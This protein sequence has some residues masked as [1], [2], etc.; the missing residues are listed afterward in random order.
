MGLSGSRRVW[1][2][3][4]NCKQWEPQAR[5]VQRG[6]KW[7]AAAAAAAAATPLWWQEHLA[8]A[9][10]VWQGTVL[11]EEQDSQYRYLQQAGA[12]QHH[13]GQQ[14][15]RV[16]APRSSWPGAAAGPCLLPG[17]HKP[18]CSCRALEGQRGEGSLTMRVSSIQGLWH[19][20]ELPTALPANSTASGWPT[21]VQRGCCST[22]TVCGSV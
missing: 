7:A 13:H 8:R 14:Q 11:Q 16:L 4:G 1:A 17:W 20:G 15:Q 21:G 3:N 19:L 12:C 10:L 18:P 2:R 9:G 5:A 22:H 6:G